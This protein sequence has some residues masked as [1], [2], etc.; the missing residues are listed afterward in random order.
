MRRRLFIGLGIGALAAALAWIAGSTRFGGRLENATYDLRLART[1]RPVDPQSPVVVIE[2]N[3]SSVRALEPIVGRWP[4]PR[5]IHAG[6]I[7]FLTY[8]RARVVAYDV[9]FSERDTRGEF[10]IGDQQMT[11]ADSDAQL[12]ASVR[13]AGNVVLAA[14]ATYQGSVG[15]PTGTAAADTGGPPALSGTVYHPGPG[16]EARPSLRLPFAELAQ[17]AAA[18]GHTY[19]VDDP[20]GEARRM[21]PFIDVQGVA[22]PSLGLAAVLAGTQAA[23]GDVAL[24]GDTLRIGT[25]L[26]PLLAAPVP[27]VE[28]GGAAQPS[29]QVLLDFPRAVTTRDGTTSTYPVY[30]FFNVLLSEEQVSSGQKPAIDP[31]VF[32]DKVVFIGTSAAGLGDVRSTP[33]GGGGAPGVMLHATLAD[34]VLGG[35]LMRRAPVRVDAAVTIGVGLAAGLLAVLLPVAWG[36]PAVLALG[37]LAVVWLTREVGAGEWIGAVRPL[38]AGAVAL[39]SGVAWQYFVEGRSKRQV[40]QLFGRYVSKD[41]IEEL[42]ADPSLARLGGQRRE[43][44]VLFS[45]IR[46]FT[47]VSERGTPESIVAQLNEYFTAMVDV[48]FRH[49]GTLDKFVGDMVMGLFGAPV[50]DPRHADHAVA[51]AVDMM[52]TLGRLNARWEAEGR[53]RLDIGIGI[54]SGDMIAGNIGSNAIMSYTVIG[55]AVNLGSRLESLNKEYRTHI[56]ISEETRDRLT[57][58]VETRRIGEVKVKGRAQ[59]VVVYEVLTQGGD[60]GPREGART[61]SGEQAS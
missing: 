3:E 20:D 17:A 57:E 9:L 49:Q 44:S 59:P 48:L 52:A 45:D 15:E 51:A 6:V 11:G 29:R 12:V 36:T 1:A 28:P 61:S 16:F 27:P 54:N 10:R 60:G 50:A 14:E 7:D 34:N 47:S 39:F 41:V 46:G 23:A 53:P 22:V 4:W 30:S 32:R 2:I 31:A 55:D 19:F 42:L 13:R 8:A 40:R 43:M 58:P 37:A 18:I 56:L 25:R 5:L 21:V 35:R 38:A 24:Q 26:V 33:M